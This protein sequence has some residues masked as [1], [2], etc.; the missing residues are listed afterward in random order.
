MYWAHRLHATVLNSIGA[1]IVQS[2]VSQHAVRSALPSSAD[3]LARLRR[4]LV[5]L[6][7]E[8]RALASSA[9]R[10]RGGTLRGEDAEAVA[11]IRRLGIAAQARIRG[12]VGAVPQRIAGGAAVV[13]EE[14]LANAVRHGRPAAIEVEVTVRAAALLIRVRDD[15]V[16]CEVT[17]FDEAA[18][19][20]RCG[21]AIMRAQA[22]MLGGRLELS[23]VPGR[24]TQVSLFVPLPAPR[25]RGV[26]AFAGHPRAAP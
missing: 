8:A 23:S 19:L 17:R 18:S 15:G 24:G 12:R 4:M 11:A 26:R 13:L 7:E 10:H 21:V 3:E 5:T 9:A 1:V 2:Q 16:G 6:E 25:R 22:S 20:P 14:A